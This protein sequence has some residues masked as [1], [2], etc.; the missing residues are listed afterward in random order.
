MAVG[1]CQ[2]KRAEKINLTK[3]LIQ[4]IFK[5]NNKRDSHVCVQ[6]KRSVEKAGKNN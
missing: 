1:K 6:V 5:A 3:N 2:S 4:F